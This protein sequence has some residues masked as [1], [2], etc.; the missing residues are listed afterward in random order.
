[1]TENSERLISL[2]LA[3]NKH[4]NKQLP[5]VVKTV[6][7][8][9]TVDV[10]IIKNDDTQ[11]VV[12]CNVPV[13]HT[14]TQRAFIFLGLSR[15]DRGLIKFFDKSIESYKQTG[16]EEYNE[17][18]RNHSDNDGIFEM[19][20]YPKSEAY[21]FP[22]NKNIAIGNK[23]GSA[24]ISIGTTGAIILNGVNVT[25]A[26]GNTTITGTSNTT[27]TGGNVSISGNTKI[28][29]KIFLAHTHTSAT[30][31]NPTSGVN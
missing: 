15:G 30:S 19:G 21:V 26:G 3:S 12:A 6:N 23:D 17:D 31:G 20:F 11:N 25:I 28:D 18:P 2:L 22:T 8:D 24:E 4:I 5:C 10:L 14:E 13:K 7:S 16:D 27:I 1:M 29:N 9:N